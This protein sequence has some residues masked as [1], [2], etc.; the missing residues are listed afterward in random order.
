MASRND[1]VLLRLEDCWVSDEMTVEEEP[2]CCTMFGG[3]SCQ[4]ANGTHSK[5]AYTVCFISLYI[6]V[7][8]LTFYISVCLFHLQY[9]HNFHECLSIPGVVLAHLPKQKHVF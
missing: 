1:P 6:Y 3:H 4:V 7:Q 2:W 5:C 9:H 8:Y